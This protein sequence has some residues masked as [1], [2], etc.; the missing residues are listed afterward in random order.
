MRKKRSAEEHSVEAEDSEPTDD[1]KDV[2]S[3]P[4]IMGARTIGFGNRASTS[5][6]QHVKMAM[7]WHLLLAAVWC[8][9]MYAWIQLATEFY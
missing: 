4:N 6:R 3:N 8:H 1:E 5:D 2:I 9:Y 7:I